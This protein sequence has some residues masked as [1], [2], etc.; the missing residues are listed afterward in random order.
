MSAPNVE[1]TVLKES[2]QP[3]RGWIV[4]LVETSGK[5][6]DAELSSLLLPVHEASL[7]SMAEDDQSQLVVKD[8][9]VQV[10]LLPFGMTTVR[11]VS[12]TA[13]A[14]TEGVKATAVTGEKVMVH[15]NATQGAYYNVYRSDDAEDP[16]TAYTLVARVQAGSFADDHLMPQGTYYYHVAAVSKTNVQGPASERAAV[17]TLATNQEPPPPIDGLTVIALTGGRRMVAWRKSPAADIREYVLYRSEG[18]TRDAH[19]MKQISVQMPSGF[20]IETYIDRDIEAAKQYRYYVVPVD[21]AGN[22]ESLPQ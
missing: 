22:R 9:K 7:C 19:A 20:S 17:T 1:V 21:W 13:P 2:E 6:T 8:N 4:R 11:L 3:G 12:G 16:P 5:A 14:A 18:S 10:H 15:W